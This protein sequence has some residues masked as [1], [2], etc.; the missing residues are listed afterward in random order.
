VTGSV[1]AAAP[2]NGVGEVIREPIGTNLAA[3]YEHGVGD[4]TVDLRMV[5]VTDATDVTVSLGVGVVTIY[6]PPNVTV[7]VNAEAGIGE[8]NVL[9][10][11]ESGF[12]P[13]I[14]ER[15]GTSPDVLSLD[16]SV[17]IG[18]VEVRR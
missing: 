17:G 9:G 6:L 10:Q 16:V 7:Q 4:F 3:S 13:S 18:Q 8:I 14:T 15:F 11:T 5:D 12:G 1:T 2:W